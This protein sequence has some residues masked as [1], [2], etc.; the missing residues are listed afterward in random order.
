MSK[1]LQRH[2]VAVKDLVQNVPSSVHTLAIVDLFCNG[3]VFNYMLH[4]GISSS[5][6]GILSE[7]ANSGAKHVTISDIGAPRMLPS[8]FSNFRMLSSLSIQ[9]LHFESLYLLPLHIQA[10]SPFLSNLSVKLVPCHMSEEIKQFIAN[11][12]NMK[13]LEFLYLTSIALSPLNT[14]NLPCCVTGN[15]KLLELKKTPVLKGVVDEMHCRAQ[16]FSPPVQIRFR[17]CLENQSVVTVL[18]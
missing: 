2:T 13:R 8:V 12:A 3:P 14:T 1:A 16:S 7:I 15:L 4:H 11:L 10:G 5:S 18:E 6:F 9:N 17:D